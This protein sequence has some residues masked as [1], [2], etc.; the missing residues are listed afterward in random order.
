MPDA[1]LG[2]LS[3]SISAASSCDGLSDAMDAMEV[4][5]SECLELW[6]EPALVA[7]AMRRLA[8]PNMVKVGWVWPRPEGVVCS[9]CCFCD[10]SE[11]FVFL[12]LV[13]VYSEL[14]PLWSPR[15]CDAWLCRTW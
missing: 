1:S 2:I 4:N 11:T 5:I 7:E 6:A 3:M 9:G 14:N 8:V 12:T 10:E 15:R 13:Y